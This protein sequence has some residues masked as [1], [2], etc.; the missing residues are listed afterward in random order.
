MRTL[1]YI[2][3]TVSCSASAWAQDFEAGRE[4]LESAVD[5]PGFSGAVV[6]M[7]EGEIVY[8]DYRGLADQASGRPITQETR[9]NAASASKFLTAMA[10]VRAAREAGRDPSEV[11]ASEV[12]TDEPGLFADDLAIAALLAHATTAQSFHGDDPAVVDAMAA[13][14]SNADVFTLTR[15][16]QTAPIM[17]HPQGL[18][19]SNSGFILAGEAIARLSGESYEAYLTRTIFEPSGVAPRF[20]RQ[21]N[22]EADQLALP[23]VPEGYDYETGPPRRQPG[24]VLPADYPELADSPLGSMISSAAGGLYISARDFARIGDAALSGEIVSPEDLEWMCTSVVPAQERIFGL[25]C[26][27]R[28]LGEG[29]RRWGHNGGAPGVNTEFALYPDQGL[30]VVILSNHNMRARPVL[31]AFEAAY[32]GRPQAG[33]FIV[34]E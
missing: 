26:G 23:Y 3:M 24:Q 15:A 22:A 1:L 9:F 2:I 7:R 18:A 4:A 20:S 21:A 14:R 5:I 33:G 13:A 6:V 10:F 30:V 31:Q 29:L 11:M 34:R 8:E 25:G 19:Y 32:F 16:V 28:D 17:R 12:F 27:G